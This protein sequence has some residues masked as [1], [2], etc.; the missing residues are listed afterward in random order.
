MLARVVLNSWPQVIHLPQ[1]PKVL[2]L[3]AWATMPSLIFVF[4]FL[5]FESKS[6]FCLPGWSAVVISAHY[7]L[8]LPSSSDSSASA[9]PS[10]WKYRHLLPCLVNFCNFSR[11]RVSPFW[12]GWSQ[13]PNC[14]WSACFRLPKYWDYRCQPPLLV[15]YSQITTSPVNWVKTH[16]SP[17]GWC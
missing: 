4:I 17:R 9:F 10:S 12:P 15:P 1:P 3:E 11:D 5:Y 2:G 16:L 7:N 8:C 13:T 6:H 14:R